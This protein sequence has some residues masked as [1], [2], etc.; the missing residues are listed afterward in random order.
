MTPIEVGGGSCSILFSDYWVDF[1]DNLVCR[2]REVE[3]LRRQR[4]T[5]LESIL[6]I[7]SSASFAFGATQDRS[8]SGRDTRGN[9]READSTSVLLYGSYAED[10]ETMTMTMNLNTI[11]KHVRE[12]AGETA[13]ILEKMKEYERESKET[14]PRFA[15]ARTLVTLLDTAT[16][17]DLPH[18]LQTLWNTLGAVAAVDPE[19]PVDVMPDPTQS[20]RRI[21]EIMYEAAHPIG[22]LIQEID[23]EKSGSRLAFLLMAG[24]TGIFTATNAIDEQ[25]AEIF[26]P[27]KITASGS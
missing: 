19:S 20:A 4:I 21:V 11:Y 9:D 14:H 3:P 25:L 12:I 23:A 27:T 7:T 15:E 22:R 16:R 24:M 26:E 8:G 18:E 13:W 1:P 10:E 2:G 6:N 5:A 17:R